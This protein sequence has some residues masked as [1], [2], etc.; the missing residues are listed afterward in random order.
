MQ[1]HFYFI[2]RTQTSKSQTA[3]AAKA[4]VESTT[5]FVVTPKGEAIAIPKG[6]TNPSSPQKG[7]GMSYQGGAGGNGM[8][9]RVSGVRIM[10]ANSNQ[11]I[12]VNY[13]NK[14]GQTVDSSTGKTISN[15]DKRG[16]LPLKDF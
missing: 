10:D 4:T 8:D 9:S 6:A 14:S 16:H 5:S 15:S 2:D 11:G 1:L 3:R 7:S 13:M 12:R